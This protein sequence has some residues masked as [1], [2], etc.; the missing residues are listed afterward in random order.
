MNTKRGKQLLVSKCQCQPF[1]KYVLSTNQ[2]LLEKKIKSKYFFND[3]DSR[4]IFRVSNTVSTTNYNN[5]IAIVFYSYC[6]AKM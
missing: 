3:A 6:I 1:L 5:C 4:K 2:P